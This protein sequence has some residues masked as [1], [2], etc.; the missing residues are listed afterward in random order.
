MLSTVQ[1]AVL[2]GGLVPEIALVGKCQYM[3]TQ[4]MSVLKSCAS[5]IPSVFSVRVRDSQINPF[6]AY[7]LLYV[8]PCLKLK[9][10]SC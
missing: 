3:S 10:S 6:K 7:R 5:F 4:H 2:V 1:C 8:P 9:N